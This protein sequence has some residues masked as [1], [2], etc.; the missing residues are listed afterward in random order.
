MVDDADAEWLADICAGGHLGQRHHHDCGG[1]QRAG[2]PGAGFVERYTMK[3]QDR[4]DRLR[5][6]AAAIVKGQGRPI[7]AGPIWWRC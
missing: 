6:L 4:D 3:K 2:T 7:R 1:Q 5:S